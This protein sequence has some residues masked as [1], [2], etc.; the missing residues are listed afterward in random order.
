MYKYALRYIST[1]Y[2]YTTR[3][4]IYIYILKSR[5]CTQTKRCCSVCVHTPLCIIGTNVIPPVGH[6]DSM[7]Y[8]PKEVG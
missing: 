8:L 4:M 7:W 5:R 3:Y 6:D 1:L 2:T